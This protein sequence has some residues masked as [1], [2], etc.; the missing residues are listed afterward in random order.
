MKF[1]GAPAKPTAVQPSAS[2]SQIASHADL[3]S[4]NEIEASGPVQ[5]QSELHTKMLYIA[6]SMGFYFSARPSMGTKCHY[7]H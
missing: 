7:F 5:T 3:P 6:I 2:L 4:N 1:F